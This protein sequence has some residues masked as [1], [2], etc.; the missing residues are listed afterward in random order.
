MKHA[1]TL[2]QMEG[3]IARVTRFLEARGFG[4]GQ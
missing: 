4:P 2:A 1:P 3:I